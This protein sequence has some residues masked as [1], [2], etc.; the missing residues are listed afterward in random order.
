M[1]LAA[2]V[3]S[4]TYSEGN[5]EQASLKAPSTYR[6]GQAGSLPLPAYHH[7]I[8]LF[9]PFWRQTGWRKEV[10]RHTRRSVSLSLWEEEG[11]TGREGGREAGAAC[12]PRTV[13]ITDL[14][15]FLQCRE[16]P[17]LLSLGHHVETGGGPDSIWFYNM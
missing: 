6:A 11:R 5:S 13:E 17:P 15:R 2:A 7:L 1:L 16:T 14:D 8:L 4:P 9:L 3:P 12:L 10:G